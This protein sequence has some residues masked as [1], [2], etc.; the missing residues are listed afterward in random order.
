MRRRPLLCVSLRMCMEESLL[1]SFLLA[2]TSWSHG[3]TCT[4]IRTSVLGR[5]SQCVLVTVLSPPEELGRVPMMHQCRV[6]PGVGFLQNLWYIGV[7]PS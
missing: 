5:Y 7:L 1:S 3:Q 2:D 6:W 4:P